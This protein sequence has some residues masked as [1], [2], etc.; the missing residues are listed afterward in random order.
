MTNRIQ[1]LTSKFGPD[2]I[3]KI[4]RHCKGGSIPSWHMAITDECF[5]RCPMCGHWKRNDKRTLS[6]E[7]ILH[8]VDV[9]QQMGLETVALTG[10]DPM[11]HPDI[12]LILIGLIDRQI[13]FGVVTAGYVPTY[14]TTKLL[15]RAQWVRVSLDAVDPHIYDQ[16]R[17]GHITYGQVERSLL[18]MMDV[19]VNIQFGITVNSINAAH[20]PAILE[21][22]NDWADSYDAGGKSS[23]SKV[24]VRAVYHHSD[25]LRASEALGAEAARSIQCSRVVFDLHSIKHEIELERDPLMA[26]D[27]CHAVRYQLFVDAAGGVYPCC[28][29]GGDTESRTLTSPLASIDAIDMLVRMRQYWKDLPAQ[30]LPPACHQDCPTRLNLINHCWPILNERKDFY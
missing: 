21:Q 15:K 24:A 19:G 7:R 13:A 9:A 4:A 28:V 2:R 3:L 17:G 14:A 5:N 16:A 26:F 18:T 1:E 10:G 30:E 27:H 12:D 29:M 8:F 23:I 22:I 6:A 25:R 20:L 11:A